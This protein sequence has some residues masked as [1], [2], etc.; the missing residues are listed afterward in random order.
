MN[1]QNNS[2]KG[3]RNLLVRGLLGATGWYTTGDS[4]CFTGFTLP[5]EYAAACLMASS[6]WVSM[7]S[8][9]G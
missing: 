4:G 6:S 3:F 2:A 7:F 8:Y 1:G 9:V 5:L